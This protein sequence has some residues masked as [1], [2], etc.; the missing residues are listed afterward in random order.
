MKWK[1]KR[2]GEIGFRMEMGQTRV[3]ERENLSTALLFLL[4]ESKSA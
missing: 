1:S 2:E 4:P 3:V